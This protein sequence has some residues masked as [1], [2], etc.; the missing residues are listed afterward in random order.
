MIIRGTVVRGKQEARSLG[1]PTANVAHEVAGLPPG[2][3]IA[4]VHADTAVYRALG[5]VG[6]WDQENGHASLE[7]H[8]LDFF[9]ELYKKTLTIALYEKIRDL[10]QFS[11][12]GV[13]I[14]R[15]QQDVTHARQ[16]FEKNRDSDTKQS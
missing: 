16:Y 13:L 4:R 11:D 5:V 8:L 1:F 7:A 6:M 10:E 3:Y 2:V 15:I 14:A 9:G 12:R